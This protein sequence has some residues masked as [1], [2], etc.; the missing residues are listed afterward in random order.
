MTIGVVLRPDRTQPNLVDDVI[1]QA[2][3]LYETGVDQ[4]WLAQQFD[5]DAISLAGL[6]GA[7]VTGLGVGTFVVP[8]NPRH[9][10][11][12]AAQ[13]QTAQAAT[14]GRFSLGLGLGSHEPERHAFGVS[15][16]D[17]AGRLREHLTVLRSVFDDG[18]VDHRGP[19]LTAAPQWPVSVPGGTPIPVYVAAMGPK[20]LQVTGELADGTLPYLAGPRAIAEFITHA[21][22]LGLLVHIDGSRIANATAALGVE[23]LTATGDADIITVGGT[24]NGALLGDAVLVRRPDEFHGIRFVHKQIGHLASKHRYVAAQ[25]TA[26]LDGGLWLRL[27]AHANEM[28]A[29]LSGGLV[30]L[31]VELAVPTEAN[32]VFVNLAPDAYAA[33]SQHYSVHKP[34]PLAPT[35]RFVCSWSTTADEVDDVL[36]LYTGLPSAPSA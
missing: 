21:H 20:A 23:P 14:H 22:D 15:W 25:F 9:P 29:R 2:T 31:G 26:L 11:L 10:L 36:Q 32:E 18:A 30:D 12:V 3:E 24:K 13:A 1:E 7:A 5:H 17:P 28:A 6:V 19:I 34:D 35:V 33:L 16:P 4:I 8:I 27:A